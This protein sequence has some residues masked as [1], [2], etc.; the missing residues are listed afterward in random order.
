MSTY[1]DINSEKYM[2]DSLDISKHGRHYLSDPTSLPH[3]IEYI[4]DV[5]SKICR[6]N[7]RVNRFYSVAEH[8]VCVSHLVQCKHP[9]DL[10]LIKYSLLHD[11]GEVWY[12][13]ITRPIRSF[14]DHSKHI[15]LEKKFREHAFKALTG[16]DFSDRFMEC[17]DYFDQ[18]AGLTEGIVLVNQKEFSSF[19]KELN[20]DNDDWTY[21]CKYKKMMWCTP[22]DKAAEHFLNRFRSLNKEV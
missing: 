14:L 16:V 11:I 9:D 4:A 7:G 12:G 6:F 15:E 2:L 3:D 8:S 13:D 1:N 18:I 5:L 20:F 21:V 22:H 19:C 10:D 17:I